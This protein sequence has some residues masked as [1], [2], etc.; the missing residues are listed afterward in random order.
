MCA[1]SDCYQLTL[2]TDATFH[3][4]NGRWMN[5]QLWARWCRTLNVDASTD[6]SRAVIASHHFLK[7]YLRYVSGDH[8]PFARPPVRPAVRP[9]LAKAHAACAQG[10]TLHR[11]GE[12]AGV[13]RLCGHPREWTAG[14]IRVDGKHP[15]R[16]HRQSPPE[17]SG[18]GAQGQYGR[19]GP[20]AHTRHCCDCGRQRYNHG[21]VS[22]ADGDSRGGSRASGRQNPS[23]RPSG[24]KGGRREGK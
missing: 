20:V 12:E 8:R 6:R 3:C 4:A 19:R 7:K 24:S 1:D 21:V 18:R 15:R 23:C 22:A 5:D 13:H 2:S 16:R 11:R 14:P 10:G 9:P 17:A